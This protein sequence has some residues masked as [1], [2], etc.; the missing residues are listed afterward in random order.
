V[1]RWQL[2][3]VPPAGERKIE[4]DIMAVNHKG[5]VRDSVP[6]RVARLL[7]AHAMPLMS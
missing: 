1:K 3:S 4:G 2:G 7:T 5:T 6:S